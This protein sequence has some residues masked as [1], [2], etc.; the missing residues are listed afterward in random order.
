V[1]GHAGNDRGSLLAEGGEERGG[2]RHVELVRL[3]ERLDGLG[4]R[5]AVVP[6]PGHRPRFDGHRDVGD[7]VQRGDAGRQAGGGVLGA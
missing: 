4:V 3:A 2:E 5:I 1:R 6:E 7:P